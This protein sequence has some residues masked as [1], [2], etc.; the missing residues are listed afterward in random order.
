MRVSISEDNLEF[1]EALASPVRLKIIGC[2]SKRSMNIK[3]LAEN[4]GVSSAS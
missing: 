2:L 1:F 3:E 4:V